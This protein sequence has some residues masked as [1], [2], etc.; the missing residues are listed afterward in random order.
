MDDLLNSVDNS[1]NP[2]VQGNVKEKK[3]VTINRLVDNNDG[4]ADL[5]LL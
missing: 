1:I 5:N 2:D 3:I 4:T